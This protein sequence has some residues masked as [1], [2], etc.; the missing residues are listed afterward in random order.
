MPTKE[1]YELAKKV[2]EEYEKELLDKPITVTS[3]PNDEKIWQL[4]LEVA[5]I[6]APLVRAVA[7][8]YHE[9]GAKWMRD[10]ILKQSSGE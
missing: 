4:S 1:E 2:I 8:H 6:E 9:K 10:Q 5:K 3:L 7:S